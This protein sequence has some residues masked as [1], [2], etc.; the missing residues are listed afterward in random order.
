MARSYGMRHT[1]VRVSTVSLTTF[2]KGLGLFGDSAPEE[3]DDHALIG[4]HLGGVGEAVDDL[5]GHDQDKR[6]AFRE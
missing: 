5:L 4:L 2:L 3:S 6:R 1:F